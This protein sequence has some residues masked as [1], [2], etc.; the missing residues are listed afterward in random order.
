MDTKRCLSCR[1]VLRADAHS[2]SRCGYVFSQAP[3][4]RNGSAANGSRRSATASFPSNPPASQHR[5]GHYS[6]FHPEDQ[7]F[8]SSFMPVQR[9]PAI[10]RRLVEQEPGEILQPVASASTAAPQLAP[11]TELPVPEQLP[12]RYVASPA[13][14]PSPMPQRYP[15]APSQTSAPV[16]QL[17]FVAPPLPP[18]PALHEQIT[19]PLPEPVYLPGKRQPRNRIVRNLLLASFLFFLLA[20]GILASLFLGKSPV[21]S[22]H[23]VLT[24][25]PDALRVHDSFLLSG[26]AFQANEPVSL[27]RDVNIPM[28]DSAGKPLDVLTDGKGNFA[29]QI[30]ITD[31]WGIGTHSIYATDNVHSRVATTITI[32]QPPHTPPKLQLPTSPIDFGADVPGAISHKTITLT[33][34]GGGQ[35]DWQA[36]S[37]SPSWLT[38]SPT[39]GTFFGKRLVTLTVNRANL[40]PQAYTGYITFYQNEKNTPLTLKVT[41]MVSPFAANLSLAP[42][43]LTF[44]GST[45][46]NPA[47]QA[48]TVQNTGG[49]ALDWTVIIGTSTGV[50]WLN[51]SNASGHLEANSQQTITVSANS[52][53]LVIGSYQGS[54]TFSYAGGTPAIQV[55]VTLTVSPPPLPAIVVKSN[56]LSF[57]TIQGTNPAPQTFTITNTGN[58]PL[59]W[60]ITEDGNA[61]A[62][63][64][65]SSNRGNLAPG[66]SAVITVKPNVAA[67][68]VRAITGHITISDTDKGTSVQSQQVT[69]TITISNQAVISVSTTSLTFNSTSTKEAPAQ[70]LTITNTGSAPLNW[71]LSP[72]PSWLLADIQSGTLA[73][74]ESAFVNVAPNSTGLSPSPPS[75]PNTCSLVVSDTDAHTPVT[76]QK[77]LV[78]LTV[79]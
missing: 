64:P 55:L 69:V 32:Q 10:T 40:A 68:T 18:E 9:P 2:C 26:S 12:R 67:S 73:P 52:V 19:A 23:P 33:N 47:I 6:G 51:M 74:N 28:K 59:N 21:A 24:A 43:S 54:L 31:N 53:G 41:M 37:D 30:A 58:A 77:V 71:T 63:A 65:V 50:K 29:V 20:T 44:N 75:Y 7:P 34:T 38:I 57:S 14:S 8:Q 35:I 13:P 36:G 27:T 66:T 62:F 45:T 46:Q 70:L 78:T 22:T 25:A 61:A 79:T 42:A 11:A 4:K 56:A 76:P 5:A 1:K 49:Q 72:L 15:G 3:V 16:P 39:G 60:A 48:I 17:Q